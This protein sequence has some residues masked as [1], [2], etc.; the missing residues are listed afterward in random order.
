MWKQCSLD[1][2]HKVI[3]SECN[4]NL[5]DPPG[6][7]VIIPFRF[8][9]PYWTAIGESTIGQSTCRSVFGATCPINETSVGNDAF[10]FTPKHGHIICFRLGPQAGRAGDATSQF[11]GLPVLWKLRGLR[12]RSTETGRESLR[13]IL[14]Q[15]RQVRRLYAPSFAITIFSRTQRSRNDSRICQLR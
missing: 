5:A 14:A 9:T 1:V 10:L 4:P 7:W 3:P 8:G 12:L 2:P 13:R 15:I 6:L 11:R